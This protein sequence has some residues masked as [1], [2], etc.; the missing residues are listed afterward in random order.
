M[1]AAKKLE[2][3]GTERSEWPNMHTEN[4]DGGFEK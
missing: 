1:G 4:Q 3:R 2:T